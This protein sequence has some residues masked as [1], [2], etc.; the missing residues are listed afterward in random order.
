MK[1]NSECL[2]SYSLK[3]PSTLR[4][5]SDLNSRNWLFG[6]ANARLLEIVKLDSEFIIVKRIHAEQ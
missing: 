3:V 6:I 1:T 5:V 2:F 4:F